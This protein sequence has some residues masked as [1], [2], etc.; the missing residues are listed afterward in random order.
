[1]EIDIYAFSLGLLGTVLN[2][3]KK[4]I[5]FIVWFVSS[6]LWVIVGIINELHGLTARG[7]VYSILALY[8][9]YKWKVDK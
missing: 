2:I 8:G 5:C 7:I 1:M 6:S 4:R 9:Y 3:H